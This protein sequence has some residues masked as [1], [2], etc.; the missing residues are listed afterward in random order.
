MEKVSRRKFVATAAVAGAAIYADNRPRRVRDHAALFLG[1]RRRNFGD[2]ES[3]NLIRD[4]AKH[5]AKKPRQFIFQSEPSHDPRREK[6]ESHS[7]GERKN[8]FDRDAP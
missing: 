6:R 2:R 8:L 7:P 3:A 4:Q 5:L 1:E